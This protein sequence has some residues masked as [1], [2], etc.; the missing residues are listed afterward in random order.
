M[1]A[2]HKSI[3]WRL[4]AWHGALLLLVL[5]AFGFT[6]YW[7]VRD[8]RY[9][10]VDAEMLKHITSLAPGF[11]PRARGALRPGAGLPAPGEE[12]VSM[13]Q[14]VEAAYYYIAWDGS[15]K[16]E[17][18]SEAAPADVPMPE[19]RRL[20]A[21]GSI[22]Q[23]G[24]FRELFMLTQRRPGFPFGPA[25]RAAETAPMVLLVGRST[26][27]IE[28]EL[29][30]VALLFLVVG[31]GVLA[32]G[33]SIGWL[34]S[35]KTIRPINVISAT[36][37]SISTGNL[38]GRIKLTDTEDELGELA[39]VLNETFDRLQTAFA[40][41]AQ[42]TA[43]ASHE[44]RT[45][46]FVILSE[47]QSALKRSR[48]EAEY[49]ESFAVCQRAAQ[50]MRQL[51]ESLLILSRED[52]GENGRRREPCALDQIAGEAVEL[53]RTLAAERKVTL[54]LDLKPTQ[55]AGDALQLKQVVSNL[56]NNAIE[57]NRPGGEVTVVVRPENH[58]AV[59]IVSDNG[60][61]IAGEDMPHIFKRFYRADKSRSTTDGHTGLGLA[62]CQAIVE[63]HGGTILAENG[64]SGGA[65]FTVRLPGAASSARG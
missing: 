4:Q 49:R 42:F 7:V 13:G 57:Y 54:H 56:V 28:A 41:Q 34:I 58:G 8:N 60:P 15:G 6:G 53:Q 43:D 1:R 31:G 32:F 48:T 37:K 65:I 64:V 14:N 51:I 9:N 29:N 21:K 24:E 36:A 46:T 26:A 63:A 62:I 47:A 40:R 16:V 52:A 22:R 12:D 11:R 10:Q 2:F 59:L 33:L 18:A 5:M 3:R 23:R 19:W 27:E 30:R 55:L 39:Q 17:R 50:Q 38:S 45:P 25:A 44:L 35:D 61:G 20:S